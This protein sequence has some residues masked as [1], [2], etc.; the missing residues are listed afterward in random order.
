MDSFIFRSQQS[1]FLDFANFWKSFQCFI[2]EV[3][4]KI[5]IFKK[6][7]KPKIKLEFCQIPGHLWIL[8]DVLQS[9]FRHACLYKQQV[10]MIL[11]LKRMFWPKKTLVLEFPNH[12][13]LDAKIFFPH[14]W[15]K[16]T[17]SPW[18]NFFFAKELD[19][20]H[21]FYSLSDFL[22]IDQDVESWPWVMN[23]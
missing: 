14:C 5:W 22:C 1:F 6:K 4:D 7:K 9:S 12:I 16:H 8:K 15:R 13:F 10:Q 18:I 23:Y 17:C 2:P 19:L 21:L 11:N 3:L 20:L